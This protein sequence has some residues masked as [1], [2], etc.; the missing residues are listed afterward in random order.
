MNRI[1]V[2]IDETLLHFL[3]NMAKYHKME[4]PCKRFRYVYRNIFDITEAR[5]KRMVIDFY[6]S[7][8]FHDL[9]PMKGS[10]E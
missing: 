4:L 3:P 1:A 8:E 6:N 5:S 7:Q 9:E 2:D 10:Q